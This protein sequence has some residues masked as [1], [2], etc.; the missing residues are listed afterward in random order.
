MSSVKTD[1]EIT[2]M[3]KSGQILALVLERMR[4]ESV[5]GLTPK[6]MSRRAKQE[7]FRLGGQ[8][9]FLGFHGHPGA[10]DYPDIICISVN[11]EVQH[12]IPSNRPFVAGDVVNFD[13]GVRYDGMVTDAGISV[14]I[15]GDKY[16]QS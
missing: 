12:A 1:A 3:R 11:N 15:G 13:F 16:L 6:E 5:P 9:V 8:P 14:C 4:K 7:L 10:R 2:A